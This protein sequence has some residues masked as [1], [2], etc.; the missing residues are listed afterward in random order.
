MKKQLF[1]R[2]ITAVLFNCIMAVFF[3][4]LLGVNPL[5]AVIVWNVVSF[6]FGN[7]FTNRVPSILRAGLSQE[8]WLP[9]LIENFYPDSSFIKEAEDMSEFVE[10]DTINLAFAGDDPEVLKNN[11]TF[12]VPFAQRTDTPGAL[13][14][15]TYTT[16]GT[17]IRDSET[18]ELSYDKRQS[19][20]AGHKNQLANFIGKDAA[21]GF[22]PAANTAWTP[23]LDKTG[24]T[25][26]KFSYLIDM[27]KAY[28]DLEVPE[29]QRVAVL[30]TKALADLAK[31][32]M[33]LFNQ[34]TAKAGSSVFGFKIYSFSQLPY[35]TA[36]TKLR[37]AFG[38]TP[39]VG[40]VQA[41]IFFAKKAVM[42]SLGSS[43]MF[44]RLNDPE[45][46]GDII[47]FEQRA[48]AMAKRQRFLGAIIQ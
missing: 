28:N 31:E 21:H 24:D 48:L 42:S 39:G 5:I 37:K 19:V 41:S 45:Q 20:L 27:Q 2:N 9:D 22:A 7:P 14:L 44:A 15:N 38:S 36:A 10:Y 4:S 8:I 25:E 35:Y 6:R 33:T 43:K 13:V 17:V 40:D 26:F 12:P 18:V 23:V 46:M 34:I 3:A 47:N 16:K 11:N 32:N 30:T 29:D 1:L